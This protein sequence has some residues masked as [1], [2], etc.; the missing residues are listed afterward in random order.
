MLE[1]IEDRNARRMMLRASGTVRKSDVES[2]LAAASRP[3]LVID[4]DP[5]FDGYLAEIARGLASTTAEQSA[6]EHV[7]LVMDAALLPEAEISGF[8]HSRRPTR[9]FARRDRRA[10]DDW[11]SGES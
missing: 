7:A 9:L 11:A 2:A 3:G 8:A 4:V 6:V 10:A 5:D 1:R